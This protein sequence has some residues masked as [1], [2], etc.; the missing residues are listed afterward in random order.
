VNRRGNHQVVGASRHAREGED[1]ARIAHVLA[2]R[3]SGNRRTIGH[4]RRVPSGDWISL[5]RLSAQLVEA[6]ILRAGPTRVRQGHSIFVMPSGAPGAEN[7]SSERHGLTQTVEQLRVFLSATLD[8]HHAALLRHRAHRDRQ[9]AASS[10]R[11][12]DDLRRASCEV[13]EHIARQP[14][15]RRPSRAHRAPLPRSPL[16]PAGCP[17]RVPAHSEL[18]GMMEKE[19][20]ARSM[21]RPAL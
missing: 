8:I 14:C 4:N 18:E 1:T 9:A 5:W 13:P 16:V 2:H 7:V 12:G 21:R 19:E 10:V 11:P 6:G 3:A 20:S 15:T 17:S